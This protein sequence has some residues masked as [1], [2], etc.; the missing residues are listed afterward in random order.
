MTVLIQLSVGTRK[1][2]ADAAHLLPGATP[3]H[4]ANYLYFF[5]TILQAGLILQWA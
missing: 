5:Y 2:D 1:E 4:A 3:S